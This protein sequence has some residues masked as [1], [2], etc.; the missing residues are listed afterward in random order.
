MIQRFAY[1]WS[2]CSYHFVIAHT[3]SAVNNEDIA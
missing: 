2:A 1:G 3:T